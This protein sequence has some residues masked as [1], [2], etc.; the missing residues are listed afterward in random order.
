MNRNKLQKTPVKCFNNWVE[1][2]EIEANFR[3]KEEGRQTGGE[4]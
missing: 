1:A 2:L 4:E 3:F